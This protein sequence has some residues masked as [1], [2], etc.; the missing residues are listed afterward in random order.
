MENENKIS[1][2][3]I[4]VFILVLIGILVTIDLAYIYYQA[5]FNSHA[6]PSFCSV[7][8]FIDCD[9][10][11]RT[12][13]SQFLGVPLA[14]W[15]LFLYSFMI[16]ML[17]VDKLKKIPF[18][19]FLEVFKN[20]YHYIASLGLIS[21]VISMLLTLIN[22]CIDFKKPLQRASSPSNQQNKSASPHK[23]ASLLELP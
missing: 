14:L 8:E 11:A 21:F 16:L 3:G 17:W 4:I 15:G 19:K 2:K 10:V 23:E 1:K 9:G 12:V 18:L 6:L 7:N 20:K 13:E 22:S 5:N